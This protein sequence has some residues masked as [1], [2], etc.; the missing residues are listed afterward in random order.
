M[1]RINSYSETTKPIS[2]PERADKIYKFLDRINAYEYIQDVM[3]GQEEK[4]SF[5]DFKNFL[6]RINGIARDISI[7]QRSFDGNEVQ[8]TG[9]VDT[10][11]V[12]KHEDKETLLKY[13]YDNL[14]KVKKGE[15]K[16]LIPVVINAL[17]FFNDGNGRTSRVM[18]QLL[19]KHDSKE[20]FEREM[21]LALG[22]DG[23]WDCPDVSPGLIWADV[24]KIILE[25]YGWNFGEKDYP[26]V[27]LG[28]ITAGIAAVEFNKIDK[29]HP[30]YDLA[31]KCFD[32]SKDDIFY[33]LTAIHGVLGEEVINL[34]TDKLEVKRI[35]P[36]KLVD[37]LTQEQWQNILDSYYKL[38]EEHVKIII[39]SFLAPDKFKS[40]HNKDTNLK[41][42]FIEQV[43]KN[44]EKYKTE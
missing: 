14:E 30:S 15:E 4:P 39:D 41:D 17:H 1:E 13:V 35:S 44:H 36:I 12:P 7:K 10:V 11:L 20:K 33:I 26:P 22:E 23:R 29:N 25:K 21:K 32:I 37:K 34:L 18:Y 16:Y 5:E 9:F 31:K 27:S 43:K 28:G 8:L 24:E 40:Y 42:Y 6:I 3:G 19:E 2:R 38:K